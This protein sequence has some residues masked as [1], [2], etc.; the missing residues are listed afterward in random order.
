MQAI[1][2]EFSVMM[3]AF[4][5]SKMRG[6]LLEFE[7]FDGLGA[8]YLSIPRLNVIMIFLQ[9]Y[10][11]ER[12]LIYQN[13]FSDVRLLFVLLPMTALRILKTFDPFVVLYQQAI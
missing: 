7:L 4:D 5:L 10:N 13:L 9:E 1:Q 8:S 12:V 2:Q 6:T 11:S 3:R